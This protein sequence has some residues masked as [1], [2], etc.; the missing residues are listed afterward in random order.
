MSVNEIP[1]DDFARRFSIRAK[2]LMWFLGAGAS[3]SAGLPT[4]MD[5]IWEFKHSIFLS[6]NP[7]AGYASSN[8]SDP[9]V[10]NRID[11]H[12]KSIDG[13]P[14]PGAPN[15]YAALFEA[16]Y[17][18]SHRCTSQV[19]DAMVCLHRVPQMNTPHCSKQHIPRS[20][21]AARYWMPNYLEPNH[22]MAKWHLER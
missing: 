21:I 15:E 16:A 8:L 14:P 6:Q 12:L 4:A 18:E 17:P 13:L 10:R 20:Q 22:L 19:V 5:M 3:A 7:G 9:V 11:A 2:N 1:F